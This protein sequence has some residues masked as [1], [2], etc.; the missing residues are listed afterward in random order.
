M[1][2]NN[3]GFKSKLRKQYVI[4]IGMEGSKGRRKTI[5]YESLK[6]YPLSSFK[7]QINE[8]LFVKS[9]KTG[10]I[11]NYKTRFLMFKF[12]IHFENDNFQL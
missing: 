6:I 2:S 1:I 5:G 3:N 9:I 8:A 12:I 10:V 4:K 11:I 7:L